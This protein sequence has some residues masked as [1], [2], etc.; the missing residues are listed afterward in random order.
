M[1]CLSFSL[2]GVLA[3][4]DAWPFRAAQGRSHHNQYM[5]VYDNGKSAVR[6]REGVTVSSV[7]SWNTRAASDA[8]T[9]GDGDGGKALADRTGVVHP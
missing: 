7:H 2:V 6:V 3:T 5:L 9:H 1:C 4:R 8:D